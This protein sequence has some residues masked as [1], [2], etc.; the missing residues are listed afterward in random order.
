MQT[1]LSPPTKVATCVQL[2]SPASDPSGEAQY[3]RALTF[4]QG[5]REGLLDRE[6]GVGED[7][8]VVL[9]VGGFGE[10]CSDAKKL[11]IELSKNAFVIYRF[12][13]ERCSLLS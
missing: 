9:V 6:I 7:K 10:V 1:S 8:R 12:Q 11:K 5:W 13:V 2:I 4:S 3:R